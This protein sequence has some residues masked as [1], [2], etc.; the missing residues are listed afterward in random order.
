MKMLP[1]IDGAGYKLFN[2]K[3]FSLTDGA[4]NKLFGTKMLPHLLYGDGVILWER[5]MIVSE[6]SFYHVKDEFFTFANENTL[7]S[8]Y[9][10]GG[11]RPH[12]FAV[13]DT[14]NPDIIWMIPVSSRY[15]K[16]AA[17]YQK[18]VKKYKKCTKIVLGKCGGT[19]AAF[20][21]QNAFPTSADFLDHIHTSQGQPLTLHA[22]TAKLI[23]ENLNNNLRLHKHGIKLFFADI[24]KLYTLVSDHLKQP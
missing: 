18:Q 24:D 20:L 7:M 16:Y 1:L 2:T 22:S 13:R 14:Q 4:R 11:Y 3:M 12:F 21:I 5:I 19:D 17:E 23:V 15:A 9:E 10:G 6:G 8:N